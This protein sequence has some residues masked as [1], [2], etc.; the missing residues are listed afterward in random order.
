MGS[1]KPIENPTTHYTETRSEANPHRIN[2]GTQGPLATT[3][4]ASV[5]GSPKG[6]PAVEL[7]AV[8]VLYG[9]IHPIGCPHAG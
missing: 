7:T 4:E 9:L 5:F 2:Q 6:T 1:E 3:P 8:I